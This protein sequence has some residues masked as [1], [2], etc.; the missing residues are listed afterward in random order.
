MT[1]ALLDPVRIS[2]PV[3]WFPDQFHHWVLRIFNWLFF[4]FALLVFGVLDHREMDT[5]DGLLDL[6]DTG[7]DIGIRE[8]PVS[9]VCDVGSLPIC[10][11]FAKY[12]SN[13]PSQM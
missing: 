5:C 1:Y 13:H 3:V 12:Q 4:R 2:L 7:K 8:V 10:P 6:V 11:L 9:R